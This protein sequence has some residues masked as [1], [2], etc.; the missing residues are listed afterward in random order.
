MPIHDWT[1]VNA[2]IFHHFHHQWVGAIT[3]VLNR[4]VLPA[5]YYALTE[6]RE[7]GFE[8]DVLALRFGG[9]GRDEGPAPIARPSDEP[10]G[11]LL[12]AEPRVRITAETD[13]EFY[14]RKQN[15]VAVRHASGDDLVAIVEVVSMGN[16]AGRR[17]FDDF[18]RKAA[19]FLGRRVHL[20]ILDLQPPTSRDPQGIHGAIWDEV[21][22]EEYARPSDKPL[23]L[24]AYEAAAGIRAFIEPV[25]VGD[26][27]ID[28]PLFLKPGRHVRRADR[29]DLSPGLRLRPPALAGDPRG[30]MRRSDPHF[31]RAPREEESGAGKARASLVRRGRGGIRRLR[32]SGLGEFRPDGAVFGPGPSEQDLPVD[33]HARGRTQG[34]GQRDDQPVPAGRGLHRRRPLRGSAAALRGIA[35]SGD[36]PPDATL[37]GHASSPIGPRRA[38]IF[39]Q[40]GVDPGGGVAA[41]LAGSGLEGP[42][43]GCPWRDRSSSFRTRSSL[44]SSSSIRPFKTF[45]SPP[46]RFAA[47]RS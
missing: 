32:G 43:G 6:Q 38:S 47:A 25:A 42:A 12:V 3:D 40:P 10:G 4:R 8:P 28:M 31:S 26:T 41:G 23:T 29:G 35:P 7:A 45:G 17:A 36:A 21:A 22:W 13:L 16:K 37:G 2:G 44:A 18:L 14:R 34:E 39:A 19:E 5:E 11:G 15:V 20:L 27:P 46:P 30:A 24:A 1:R 33:D 9:P